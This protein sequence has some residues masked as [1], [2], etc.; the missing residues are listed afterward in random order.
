MAATISVNRRYIEDLNIKRKSYDLAI[1]L[2]DIDR[3]DKVVVEDG[4]RP[5]AAFAPSLNKYLAV[6]LALGLLLAVTFIFLL[7]SMDATR[8]TVDQFE[9]VT[10]LP[11]LALVPRV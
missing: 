4:N 11:T 10:G 5:T 8:H 7:E 6:G 3:T 9:K 1:G 2:N